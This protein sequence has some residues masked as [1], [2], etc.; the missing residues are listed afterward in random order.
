MTLSIDETNF[1]ALENL[2]YN[3]FQLRKVEVSPAS[4]FNSGKRLGQFDIQLLKQA[5]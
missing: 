2:S 3:Y 1:N 4:N 5:N